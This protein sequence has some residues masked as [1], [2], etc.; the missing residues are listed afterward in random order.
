[1]ANTYGITSPSQT[2]GFLRKA[3]TARIV[4]PIVGKN[5]SRSGKR[6]NRQ[7]MAPSSASRSI[8]AHHPNLDDGPH[9]FWA[10]NFLDGGNLRPSKGFL[11]ERLFAETAQAGSN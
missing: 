10:R 11:L 9:V 1:M 6:D 2:I 4:Y 7:M 8:Q 3:K 5:Y